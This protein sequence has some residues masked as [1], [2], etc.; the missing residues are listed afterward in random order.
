[1]FLSL[2]KATGSLKWVIF[3]SMANQ[4]ASVLAVA[5]Q[6]LTRGHHCSL[7]QQYAFFLIS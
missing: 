4:L 3:L 1:M 5:L 2:A 7:A 6:L